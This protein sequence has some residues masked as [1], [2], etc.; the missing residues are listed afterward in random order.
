MKIGIFGCSADPFTKA[1]LAIVTYASKRY[2]KVIIVPTTCDYYRRDK[3][4]MF[5]FDSKVYLITKMISGLEN[6]EIDTIERNQDA[7]WRTINTLEYMH[8]RYPNDEL[9]LIIGGDSWKDF[10]TWFRYEDIYMYAKLCIV[11]RNGED[12]N[13]KPETGEILTIP[14]EYNKLSATKVRNKLEAEMLDMYLSDLEWY[15]F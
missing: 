3:S 10:T 15:N 13:I 5:S 12:V 9:Y 1:H 2:D 11:P 8:E 7:K 6:V 4:P 14:E